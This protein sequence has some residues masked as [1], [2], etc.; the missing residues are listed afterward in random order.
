MITK[1]IYYKSQNYCI[2]MKYRLSNT[3]KEDL[4]RIH[5]YGI[6]KFGVIQADKYYE[7]FFKCFDIICQRPFS[8]ESV[9]YIKFGY[10]RCVCGS[11]SIY[12]RPYNG[13]VEIMTIIGKQDMKTIL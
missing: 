3:A 8:F 11:D 4:I 7:A 2:K 12:F 1:L 9:D 5:H 10:R 13:V 6:N